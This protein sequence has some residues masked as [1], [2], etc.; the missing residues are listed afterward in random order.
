LIHLIGGFIVEHGEVVFLTLEVLKLGA[1]SALVPNE[2][3][4]EVITRNYR[5]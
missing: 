3:H 5:D 2:E 1:L 4:S